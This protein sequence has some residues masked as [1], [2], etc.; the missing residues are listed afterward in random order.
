MILYRPRVQR[1]L[2][3]KHAISPRN[4]IFAPRTLGSGITRSRAELSARDWEKDAHRRGEKPLQ[5]PGA[6]KSLDVIQGPVNTRGELNSNGIAIEIDDTAIVSPRIAPSPPPSPFATASTRSRSSTG[7]KARSGNKGNG[8]KAGRSVQPAESN[9][10]CA[11]TNLSVDKEFAGSNQN[12]LAHIET[13][14]CLD[15]SGFLQY[16]QRRRPT[17]KDSRCSKGKGCSAHNSCPLFAN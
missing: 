16:A 15:S 14:V 8:G 10:I 2:C 1:S 3:N 11:R 17:G 12:F 7:T 6:E 4:L 5:C 13:S 9:K